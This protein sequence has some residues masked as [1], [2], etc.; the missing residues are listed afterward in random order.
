MREGEKAREREM[1]RAVF[2]LQ[3]SLQ[4]E[5]Y[6]GSVTIDGQTIPT[7]LS[8]CRDTIIN[9]ALSDPSH[10]ADAA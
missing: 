7:G 10:S 1:G 8:V 2:I 4:T 5:I 3:S 9:P 6:S